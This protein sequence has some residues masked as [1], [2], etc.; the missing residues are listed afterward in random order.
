VLGQANGSR[1]RW[2]TGH[3]SIMHCITFKKAISAATI[4]LTVVL[5]GGGLTA[6]GGGGSEEAIQA[7][8]VADEALTT[9]F[10][11]P[12]AVNLL[13]NDS[14]RNVGGVLALVGTPTVSNGT[15]TLVGSAI[16]VTPTP[17]F[18]GDMVVRYVVGD[19]KAANINGIATI[20]VKAALDVAAPTVTLVGASTLTLTQCD[21]YTELGATWTDAADGTGPVTAISGSVNTMVIG[22]Y[23]LTYSRT[24]AANNTGMAIR[25]VKVV[26]IQP[27]PDTTPPVITLNGAFSVS[28]TVGGTYTELGATWSD[29]V[30]GSG[31]VSDIT[32]TVNTAVVG[33]YTRTY[34]KTDA[35]GNT[36]SATRTVTVKAA[37]DTTAPLITLNG[38]ASVS[39]TVGG[40]Y[41]ELGATWSDAVDGS[42]TVSD[43]T[44]TVNTT[45]MGSYTRT[46]RKTDAA[47][48]TGSATRTV[49]VNAAADTTPPVITLNGPGTVL[50]APGTSYVEQGATWTDN[51]DGS[52]IVIDIAGTVNTGVVGIYS[53]TYRKRDDAGNIGTANRAVSVTCD[54]LIGLERETCLINY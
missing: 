39:L 46:Y 9:P 23:T 53:R 13:A 33:S 22:T 43:I 42:G 17:G 51:V 52:G 34:R 45:V 31:T 47:G 14:T 35:A 3:P 36:G 38:A 11:T 24:D 25:T 19:G 7:L 10:N 1:V 26:A 20:T 2:L 15:F 28:L 40:T 54:A 5:G 49:T 12:V 48:N 37:P 6:C 41:T 16:T 4:A 8:T 30:D 27:P 18:V 32:G 21:A 50:V 44:G 29:A